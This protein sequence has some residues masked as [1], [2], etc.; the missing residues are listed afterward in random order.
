M[1]AVFVSLQIILTAR[2]RPL[3]LIFEFLPSQ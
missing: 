2:E 1:P 3:T